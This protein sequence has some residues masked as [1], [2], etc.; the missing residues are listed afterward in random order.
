METLKKNLASL[1]W[2]PLRERRARIK[3]TLLFK[4]FNGLIDIPPQDLL[5]R[6]IYTR[7]RANTLILPQSTVNSHLYSFYPDTIRLW[8]LLPEHIKYSESLP[9]F[10]SYMDDSLICPTLRETN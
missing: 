8:N 3:V 9:T 4:A 10:K 2:L 5:S 7:S 1:G 6:Q